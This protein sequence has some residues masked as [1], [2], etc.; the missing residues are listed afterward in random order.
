LCLFAEGFTTT[1]HPVKLQI[2]LSA[3]HRK[4]EGISA[5]KSVLSSLGIAPTSSGLATISAE[6]SPHAFEKLSGVT[7]AEIAP[8]KPTAT[9]FGRSA[10]HESPPLSVPQA[11]QPF[12]ASISVAPPHV[13]MDD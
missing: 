13:F 10:G 12:V 7:A 6:M 11:L 1:P 4:P 2:L 9:D 8:S 5:V 3:G